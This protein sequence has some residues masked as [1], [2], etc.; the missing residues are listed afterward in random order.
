M[1]YFATTANLKIVK[2]FHHQLF[3]LNSFDGISNS[4]G[5]SKDALT[6][7][8][9]TVININSPDKIKERAT[10]GHMY[11]V[12]DGNIVVGTGTISDYWGSSTESILLTIFVLPEYHGKGIGKKII[13]ALENDELFM[14]STRIEVCASITACV[15]YE[16]CGYRYIDGIKQLDPEGYYR[17]EKHRINNI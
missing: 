5:E 10:K 6:S 4:L 8:S 9:E 15:F 12:C 2:F 16:K 13:K 17:M 14:R 7:K 11:V 3:D 1:K